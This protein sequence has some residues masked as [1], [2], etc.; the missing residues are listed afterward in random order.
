MNEGIVEVCD[1]GSW[2][3]ISY[4]IDHP[5]GAAE[6]KVVCRQ[7]GLPY[8]GQLLLHMKSL[9]DNSD[10]DYYCTAYTCS[11]DWLTEFIYMQLLKQKTLVMED[12][13]FIIQM[14]VVM[15]ERKGLNCVMEK[16]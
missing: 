6:A 11:Q 13:Q 1:D 8:T 5:W 9:F 10:K 15:V 3:S 12:Y 14:C 2:G 7:L 16:K 4:N